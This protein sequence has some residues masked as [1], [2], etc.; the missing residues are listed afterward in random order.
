M[1]LKHSGILSK[2]DVDIIVTNSCEILINLNL[3]VVVMRQS[4]MCSC[5]EIIVMSPYTYE[6]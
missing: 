1:S 2:Q 6:R 4:N 5:H 3:F